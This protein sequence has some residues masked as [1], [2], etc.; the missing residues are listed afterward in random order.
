M[1]AVDFCKI[2]RIVQEAKEENL[3]SNIKAS[4]ENIIASTKGYSKLFKQ[5]EVTEW[6]CNWRSYSIKKWRRKVVSLDY[7]HRRK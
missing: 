4:N 5:D 2:A 7:H 6:S 1:E 3:E